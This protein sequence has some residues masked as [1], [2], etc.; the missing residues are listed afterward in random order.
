MK[1]SL[2]YTCLLSYI[3]VPLFDESCQSDVNSVRGNCMSIG[4]VNEYP[5]MHYFGVPRHTQSMIAY[6]ILTEYFWEFQ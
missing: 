6:K 2:P 4:H 1:G 3:L 5:T